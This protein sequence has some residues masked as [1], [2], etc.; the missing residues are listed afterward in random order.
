M[1]FH[2]YCGHAHFGI[3]D[4]IP[5]QSPLELTRYLVLT[6]FSNPIH[7]LLILVNSGKCINNN[8]VM[9]AVDQVSVFVTHCSDSVP[10]GK[11]RV[12]PLLF[13][14]NTSYPGIALSF[15]FLAINCSP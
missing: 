14:T 1:A 5:S 4:K 6:T 10:D 9:F 2:Y 3:E 7:Q 13:N 11:S 8:G 15:L 12:T